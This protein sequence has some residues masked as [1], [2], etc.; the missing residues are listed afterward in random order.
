VDH[1]GTSVKTRYGNDIPTINFKII[2]S[3]DLLPWRKGFWRFEPLAL[4]GSGRYISV[5]FP[6]MASDGVDCARGR[7]RPSI[8]GF[9]GQ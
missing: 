4:W 8:K 7:I 5:E 9:R 1:A 2:V 6:D 3:R